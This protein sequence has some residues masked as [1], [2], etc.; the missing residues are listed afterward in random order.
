M[1]TPMKKRLTFVL[2]CFFFLRLNGQSNEKL[3]ALPDDF[4]ILQDRH[5]EPLLPLLGNARIIGT[6]EADHGKNEPLYFR[7]SLI[8]LLVKRKMIDVVALE[9]GVIESKVL[10]DYVFNLNNESINS[11]LESG[12]SWHFHVIPQNEELIRWLRD[13]NA[14]NN[15]SHKVKFYGFDVPGSPGN[16]SVK[17]RMNT[18]LLF[19]LGYLLKVDPATHHTFHSKLSPFLDY[20]HID[21]NNRSSQEK[22]YSQL[23]E[24][25]RQ[26]LN[27]IV[28]E[29]IKH[30]KVNELRYCSRLSIDEFDWAY[31]AA[32]SSQ[33]VLGWLEY[34][35][36]SYVPPQD[37]KELN[38]S[39]LF[40]DIFHYRDRAMFDNLEWIMKREPGS[41]IF[42]FASTNHLVKEP[43]KVLTDSS[44][45]NKEVLGNYLALRYG[46]DYKLIGNIISNA[47]V[48]GAYVEN[49]FIDK[50]HSH[51]YKPVNPEKRVMAGNTSEL[52]F[53][54]KKEQLDLYRAV[55]V[56][57][58]DNSQSDITFR[59]N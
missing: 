2:M 15:N 38:D 29:L 59:G 22:Q 3:T 23:Q 48:K 41:R 57:L 19:A 52:S 42:L 20:L 32:L 25:K 26:Q 13:Y 55:D 49:L 10:H 53:R 9:S 33:Q 39:K 4:K 5:L 8:K 11:V 28:Q 30:F 50:T 56:I 45:Y 17:R 18:S 40:K 12:F 6:S 34:I 35:P 51:Y 16:A 14:D 24:D 27:T 58:F 54:T 1:K 43:V 31:R 7:N 47:D 21:F 46:G 37:A 36:V 44:S